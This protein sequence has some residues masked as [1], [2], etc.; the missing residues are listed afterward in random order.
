MTSITHNTR[1]LRFIA[2]LLAIILLS[3]PLRADAGDDLVLFIAELTPEIAEPAIRDIPETGRK[4]LALRSYIRAGDSL[5][6][7]WSWTEAEIAAYQG[8]PEQA[9]L[10]AEV[11]R[12]RA[13]FAE[14]NPGYELYTNTRVRSLD[15]QIKRWNENESVGV[16]AQELTEA[17]EADLLSGMQGKL[18]T[19]TASKW[20]RSFRNTKRAHLAAPGLTRHGRAHAIDFQIMKD[21]AIYAGAV[22]DQIETLWR[23]GGWDVALS[24]S[25]AAA[26]PSFSGPLTSP[27][28]PWH[29]DYEPR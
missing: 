16:A 2:A 13:H 14:H 29:Y 6:G 20:L 10:L 21:G 4:L 22:A 1:F 24:K 26:G 23:A 12:I 7:R 3:H 18:D 11:D 25:I 27:D 9:V 5:S 28:E 17:M 15:I 19:K 8:S